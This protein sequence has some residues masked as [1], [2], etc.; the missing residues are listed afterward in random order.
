MSTM[1]IRYMAVLL[2]LI[3]INMS[4]NAQ[5][6][7]GGE[8]AKMTIN[9]S[10]YSPPDPDVVFA[11]KNKGLISEG[12][13]LYAELEKPVV[14]PGQ[15]VVLRLSLMNTTDKNLDLSL[16]DPE[17]DYWI[18]LKNARGE[19]LSDVVDRFVVKDASGFTWPKSSD[20]VVLPLEPGKKHTYEYPISKI[21]N[22]S[23]LGEYH[24]TASRKVYRLDGVGY[25]DVVSDTV[26]LT[27]SD[28]PQNPQAAVSQSIPCKNE[29]VTKPINTDTSPQLVEVRP[30]LERQGCSLMW[31]ADKGKVTVTAR[32][33]SATFQVGSSILVVDDRKMKMSS[34]AILVNGR[35]RAPSD[36]VS[37]ITAR[38]GG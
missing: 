35:L 15:P 5:A 16:G 30:I 8:G 31:N 20:K 24:I 33:F 17:Q 3:S 14:A 23:A 19:R 1:L 27:V 37:Q 21:F 22:L 13:L 29:K 34:P 9:T 11:E 10:D 26:I 18:D 28:N 32:G 12:F 25:A 36:A 2:V 6:T 7:D 38:C 4:A